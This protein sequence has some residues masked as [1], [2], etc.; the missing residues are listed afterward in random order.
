MIPSLR[1]KAE[2]L[3]KIN[4]SSNWG[5]IRSEARSFTSNVN[6][7]TPQRERTKISF[8]TYLEQIDKDKI[9]K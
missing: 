7:S 1:K 2:K 6:L 8:K 4:D 3:D 5:V 9:K